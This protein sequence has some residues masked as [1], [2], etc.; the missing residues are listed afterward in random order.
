MELRFL[1]RDAPFTVYH[2]TR[3][4]TVISKH[5]GK[6]IDTDQRTSFLIDCESLGKSSK[7]FEGE[8]RLRFDY[9]HRQKMY[10]FFGLF[11]GKIARDNREFILVNRISDVRESNIRA[12]PRIEISVNA[13]TFIAAGGSIPGALTAQGLTM[14]ISS[15]G[16]GMLSDNMIP[17]S[18][19]DQLYVLEF[20]LGKK[21]EFMLV[22]KLVH[23]ND[24]PKI[25]QF[26][27]LYGFLFDFTT[28]PD[29]KMRLITTML[30]YQMNRI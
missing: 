3:D 18:D 19:S 10:S 15:D 17:V 7:D 11:A 29:E 13:R 26:K 27:Y 25:I 14:D 8:I 1:D 28:Q 22:S 2:C 21:N 30:N 5:S 4:E 20:N 23:R 6:F 16:L 24:R 12:M 9:I